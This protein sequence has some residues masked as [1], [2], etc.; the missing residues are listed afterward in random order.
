MSVNPERPSI[1]QRSVLAAEVSLDFVCSFAA[2]EANKAAHTLLAQRHTESERLGEINVY[3]K[4]QDIQIIGE[5]L[6]LRSCEV[7]NREWHGISADQPFSLA[8]VQPVERTPKKVLSRFL[9]RH[10][11][12]EIEETHDQPVL[13][14][15]FGD[16]A[17]PLATFARRKDGQC[18]YVQIGSEIKD[19]N[20]HV[21]A[22]D[23]STG[24]GVIIE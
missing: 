15:K 11:D 2:A 24:R 22:T 5:E 3:C 19:D 10:I 13:V 17:L 18:S 21:L 7:I 16:V 4:R 14:A 12:T 9:R 8:L 1:D 23:D 6:D 20:F